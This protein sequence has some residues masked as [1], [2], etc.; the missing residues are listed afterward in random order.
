MDRTS[1]RD[2]GDCEDESS[3]CSSKEDLRNSAFE[4]EEKVVLRSA[5]VTVS[6][7]VVW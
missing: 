1:K 7:T 5:K 4:N 6:F 3:A 2:I